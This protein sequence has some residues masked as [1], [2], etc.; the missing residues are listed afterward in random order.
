MARRLFLPSRPSRHP[1]PNYTMVDLLHLSGKLL[2][3]ALNIKNASV[4]RLAAEVARI[5]GESKTEAIRRA[6][7]ERKA[8]LKA[9]AIE[10]DRGTRLRGFLEREVWTDVPRSERGRRLTRKQEDEILGYGSEGV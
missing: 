8:R 1:F 3:M 6:L 10:G 5:T 4:E 2:L 7:E 9:R